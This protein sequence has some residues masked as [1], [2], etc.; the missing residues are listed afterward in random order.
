MVEMRKILV[1]IGNVDF[2]FIVKKNKR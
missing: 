2:I 1:M